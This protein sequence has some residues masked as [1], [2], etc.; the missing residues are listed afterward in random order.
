[1]YVE[2]LGAY[3]DPFE[4]FVNELLVEIEGPG[5]ILVPVSLHVADKG[6][7]EVESATTKI[8]GKIDVVV[9][10]LGLDATGSTLSISKAKASFK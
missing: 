10:T 3:V 1:M 2:F 7:F 6:K 4:L 8:E 5:P 9:H